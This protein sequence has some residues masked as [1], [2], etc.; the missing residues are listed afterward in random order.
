MDVTGYMFPSRSPHVPTTKNMR[1][2]VAH[3]VKLMNNGGKLHFLSHC[4]LELY[5]IHHLDTFH[6]YS[7][8]K[9]TLVR[10]KYVLYGKRAITFLRYKIQ[11]SACSQYGHGIV[12]RAAIP[13]GNNENMN[14]ISIYAVF[15]YTY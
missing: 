9:S 4:L 1:S 10:Y 11:R 14:K 5:F 2:K 8:G 7:Q 15:N 13:L 3:S 6:S 12:Y